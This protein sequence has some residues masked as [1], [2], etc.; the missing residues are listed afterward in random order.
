[1][2]V[3]NLFATAVD[4]D[5]VWAGA[6]SAIAARFAGLPLVGYD[7]GPSLAAAR[8]AGFVTTGPLRVWMKD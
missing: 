7:H 6:V 5:R 8:R 4:E 2:G 3:S 1:V